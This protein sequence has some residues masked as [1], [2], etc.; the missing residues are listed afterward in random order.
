VNAVPAPTSL[1]R[2][3]TLRWPAGRFLPGLA[4]VGCI[5][6]AAFLLAAAVPAISPLIWAMFLGAGAGP[7]VRRAPAT[8]VG[9]ALAA[10]RLLRVGVALLGLRVALGDIADIGLG[11]A[12]LACA[13]ALTT[14]SA[15]V[16]IGRLLGVER[17][18]ALLIGAGS[19]ICGAAAVAAMDATVRAEEKDVAYAVATVTLFG[20]LAMLLVPLV[21]LHVFHLGQRETGLWAGASIHEVAQVAGAGAA[22]SVAALKVATLVKLTR[23]VLLAPMVAAVSVVSRERQ[24][25]TGTFVPAFVLAFLALVLVRSAVPLPAAVV[26]AGK[27]ISTVLLAAALAALGIQIDVRALRR[28]GARPLALGLAAW[29]VSASTAL[30]L[31]LVLQ[32]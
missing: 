32:P 1:R 27:L 12:V 11:G 17:K 6:G 14:L 5:A 31:V 3:P 10:R 23:V 21:G 4:V 13:T 22:I 8:R 29:L 16:W 2:R 7:F 15:T 28:A 20:T 24:E 30:L 19:A 9:V 25:R 26:D 18:L